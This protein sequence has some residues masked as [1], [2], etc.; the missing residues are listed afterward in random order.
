MLRPI[1][2][3][4]CYLFTTLALSASNPPPG[5]PIPSETR[6]ILEAG[7]AE[8]GAAIEDLKEKSV[9]NPKVRELLPDVIIYYNAVHHALVHD[10]FYREKDP[11]DFQIAAEF[12]RK[13][14]ERAASLKMGKAPWTRQTGLIV[15][16]YVSDIDDSV[17]PYGLEIPED[18]DFASKKPGR[19]D[20]WY[21]G[22]NNQLSELRFLHDR[23]TKPGKF[24]SDGAIVLHPFGRYCNANKFA[25][26]IDTFEALSAV[27]KQYPVDHDRVTV[28][29]FSMGGAAT[30]HMATHHAGRWAAAAPGAGFAETA[31]YANV[32][33]KDPLPT[34]YEKTLFQLYDATE[35]AANLFHCPTIAYS[36]SEDKQK[37]AAD[38]METYL[39]R[40]GIELI[41]VIGEGMGHKYDDVS[42]DTINSQMDTW[43]SQPKNRYPTSLR[44]TTYTL[45][46]SSMLW[47]NVDALDEHW[48]RSDVQAE[49]VNRERI[50]AQTANIRGFTIDFPSD[51]NPF[52]DARKRPHLLIDSQRVNLPKNAGERAIRFS[53]RK[54]DGK[55]ALAPK[56]SESSLLEK[57]PGLQGPIDDAFMS[58]FLFV[59]PSGKSRTP[60]FASWVESESQD[61]ILQWWRQ[62]RGEARVKLDTEVTEED[63]AESNLVLWGDPDS[64]GILERVLDDLPLEW[65]GQRFTL[66]SR[67]YE[68]SETA[69]T[70]IYPNPLNPKRYIVL[71]SGF[72]FSAFSGGSNSLQ[73]PKLPDWGVIDISVSRN[74]R[75]PKGILDA[76]FFDEFWRVKEK[77]E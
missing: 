73:V 36:G 13:G 60:D 35:Y 70:L 67:T 64:N 58:R 6:T 26:E 7:T 62:F 34:W 51:R 76:G 68:Q 44:F 15:R 1:Q 55:W 53:F 29:G 23:E 52:K 2:I 69:P 45:R 20:I 63:I 56:G 49:I 31:V 40:E 61:A 8:L 71:N 30:W 66:N 57:S 17:Q 38:I 9:S 74:E 59:L 24:H 11:S 12:L 42:I 25:G 41:H 21:H 39:Q 14:M 54:L 10:Q 47:L 3:L 18:Y 32:M 72:T 37:Q 27:S 46:Y 33:S 22:R 50:Q 28:R 65:K 5:I 19:L 43:L 16:G 48:K 4:A 75:H 77:T